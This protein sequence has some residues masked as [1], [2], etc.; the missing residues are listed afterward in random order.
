MDKALKDLTKEELAA[1]PRE[2]LVRRAFDYVIEAHSD[3]DE[4]NFTLLDL[5]RKACRAVNSHSIAI[6][7]CVEDVI[8]RAKQRDMDIATVLTEDDAIY[9]LERMKDGHDCNYGVSW[10][11][12][13][14]YLQEHES[15]YLEDIKDED[16][17][18]HISKTWGWYEDEYRARL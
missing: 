1:A 5:S 16:L 14:V 17:P 11:V 7:W 3:N 6:I 9:I 15:E 12:I 13:D 18:L 4:L 2:E 8:E 10:D